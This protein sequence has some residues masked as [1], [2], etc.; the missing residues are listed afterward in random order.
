VPDVVGIGI[1][2]AITKLA[3]VG[4]E[5]P[6]VTTVNSSTVAKGLVISIAPGVGV[7]IEPSAP[8]T[9]SVSDGPAIV[10]VPHLIGLTAQDAKD[11][12]I[13]A[14]LEVVVKRQ[15]VADGHPIGVVISQSPGSFT[16]VSVGSA[17][18]IVVSTKKLVILQPQITIAPLTTGLIGGLQP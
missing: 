2:H 1:D 9:L 16:E 12:L 18:E 4:I 3:N 14:G 10:K 6:A 8:V 13:E 11:S 17:V 7:S 5:N 15:I